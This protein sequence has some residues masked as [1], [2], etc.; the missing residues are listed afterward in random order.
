M[1]GSPIPAPADDSAPARPLLAAAP[2]AGGG[3][4]RR[5]GYAGPVASLRLTAATPT[6]PVPLRVHAE[7]AHNRPP[8]CC[9]HGFGPGDVP[10]GSRVRLRTAA[11][12]EIA[13]Q[14]DDETRWPDGSLKFCVLSFVA[15]DD[16]AAGRTV[17]YTVDAVP[18]GPDRTPSHSLAQLASATDFRLEVRGH[19]W[20]KA[21][22]VLSVNDAIAAGRVG[23]WGTN[24]KSGVEV[25]ASGPIRQE[26]R[27]WGVARRRGD[28]AYHESVR[29]ELYLRRW[30]A[31]GAYQLI[32]RQ[33]QPSLDAAYAGST[34]STTGWNRGNA[35]IMECFNGAALVFA[36]G[37]PKDRDARTAPPGA[38]DPRDSSY[39]VPPDQNLGQAS[40]IGSPDVGDW[41]GFGVSVGVSGGLPGGL[42]G[43]EV[44]FVGWMDRYNTAN[45]RTRFS[46]KRNDPGGEVKLTGR[47]SGPVLVY[48]LVHSWPGAGCVAADAQGD[49]FWS[50][51][52]AAPRV[53]VGH[54]AAYM[55]RASRLFAPMDLGLPRPA[56]P[57]GYDAAQWPYHP[58]RPGQVVHEK[59]W[60]WGHG[61]DDWHEDRIGWLSRQHANLLLTPF[62]RRRRTHCYA[63]AYSQADIHWDWEDQRSGRV[64]V[65]NNGP[66]RAGGTYPELAGPLP[67]LYLT[68]RDALG[69]DS[70]KPGF[71][72]MAHYNTGGSGY[73]M[74]YNPINEAS[75]YPSWQIVP[76]LQTGHR[77]FLDIMRTNTASMF[78]S[79]DAGLR[80]R[81]LRPPQVPQARQFYAI[82]WD[83]PRSSGWVRLA[84]SNLRYVLPD[85]HP[86]RRYFD[87]LAEEQATYFGAIAPHS[88][89]K[90]FGNVPLGPGDGDMTGYTSEA[91]KYNSGANQGFHHIYE[92]IGT[93]MCEYRGEDAWRPA[94]QVYL[95]FL[96]D[97]A[98]DRQAPNGTGWFTGIYAAD[99]MA[100]DGRPF[101][102]RRAWIEYA[103]R[104]QEIGPKAGPPFPPDRNWAGNHWQDGDP[105]VDQPPRGY[106]SAYDCQQCAVLALA[107]WIAD[108]DGSPAYPGCDRVRLQVINRVIAHPPGMKVRDRFP[109]SRDDKP[110][111]MGV[112]WSILPPGL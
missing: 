88:P 94:I 98:D 47:A 65:A 40:G 55:T 3:G 60:D 62:D 95:G 71:A 69:A 21:V 50:G 16:F 102:T 53:R 20:G 92:A 58:H 54:D 75:H 29:L 7:A 57:P 59:I 49:P 86:E 111:E 104:H 11:G 81:K 30:A 101:Q 6:L 45:R 42:S 52:G 89:W 110:A 97:A 105:A 10:S 24:P 38:F 28:G 80:H 15:P 41:R 44:Y 84:L 90:L 106:L 61:G 32:A 103:S 19:S 46:R 26:W 109:M 96:R 79:H 14:Q 34:W 9:G 8:V 4:A 83:Q 43:D 39:S 35:G 93:L 12:A 87:D 27:F 51:P 91:A 68:N 37:G 18:G 73:N 107:A 85:S 112:Q 108:P 13:V 63:L 74:R 48:P 77:V 1:P 64:P 23:S 67:T 33:R 76:Y 99:F 72:A 36:M 22:G 17:T 56:E 100:P 5:A 31:T 66:D 70:A 78:C 82:F 2:N 25:V